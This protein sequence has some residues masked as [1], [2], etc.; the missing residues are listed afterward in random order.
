MSRWRLRNRDGLARLGQFH[1]SPVVAAC[2]ADAIGNDVAVPVPQGQPQE[3]VL[4]PL[5]LGGHD[6]LAIAAQ[7]HAG[8]SVAKLGFLDA[9]EDHRAGGLL[10][11]KC[12][13]DDGGR[14]RRADARML[15]GD[16]RRL[17]LVDKADHAAEYRRRQHDAEQCP[18]NEEAS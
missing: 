4:V 7:A 15:A 6:P 9:G 13:R 2:D 12:R 10:L 11:G 8:Q 3:P 5:D 14:V 17:H 18:G 16:G 1:L